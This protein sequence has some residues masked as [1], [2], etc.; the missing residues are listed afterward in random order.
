MFTMCKISF[1]FAENDRIYSLKSREHPRRNTQLGQRRANTIR[2]LFPRNY[3]LL[4]RHASRHYASLRIVHLTRE[5]SNLNFFCWK[6]VNFEESHSTALRLCVVLNV[7]DKNLLKTFFWATYG[8]FL[9]ANLLFPSV[10]HFD[11]KD[12]VH[13]SVT[14]NPVPIQ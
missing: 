1:N 4:F 9:M 5:S 2:F 8:H 11:V 12:V 14:Q 7:I 6:M 13:S 10:D 3:K